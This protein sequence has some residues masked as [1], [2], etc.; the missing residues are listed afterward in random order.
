[1][2]AKNRLLEG[3]VGVGCVCIVVVD[4]YNDKVNELFCEWNSTDS[5]EII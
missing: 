3:E 5:R 2:G 1:M 4:V